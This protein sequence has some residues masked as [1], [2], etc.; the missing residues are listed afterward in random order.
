MVIVFVGFNFVNNKVGK[1]MSLLLFIIELIN[2]VINLKIIKIINI[3]GFK[4]K[5]ILVVFFLVIIVIVII[6][7]LNVKSY[8]N[9]EI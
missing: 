5:F 4:Y 2:V 6:N 7:L 1:V 9:V 3:D 8:C